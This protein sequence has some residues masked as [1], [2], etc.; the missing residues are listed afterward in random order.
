MPGMCA[1]RGSEWIQA[2]PWRGQL[3]GCGDGYTSWTVEREHVAEVRRQLAAAGALYVL[4]RE[5]HL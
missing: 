2:E 1:M 4:S 5:N 3:A